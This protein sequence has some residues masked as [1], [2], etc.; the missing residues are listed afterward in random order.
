MGRGGPAEPQLAKP[1]TTPA[2]LLAIARSGRHAASD[3]LEDAVIAGI[4]TVGCRR[5]GGGLAGACVESNV[6][7]GTALAIAQNPTSILFEGSGSMLPPVEVDATVCLVGSRD[8]ALQH[9]GPF[10]LMRS[11]LALVLPA[12]DPSDHRRRPLVPRQG[13]PDPACSR[14]RRTLP[15]GARV[16]FFTTGQ[17]D[18]S[19]ADPVVTSRNL[20]RRP[21]LAAAIEHAIRERCDV[22]VSEL[23]AAAVDTVA[24]AAQRNGARLIWARNRPCARDGEDDLDEALLAVG[25]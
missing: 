22:F 4:P 6:S 3:Y 17:G 9:L 19:D 12:D 20:A 24:E 1:H 8:G 18:L 16:A 23:K 25:R 21:E 5:V 2:E 13:D 14:G 10:R 7:A 15:A 11:A